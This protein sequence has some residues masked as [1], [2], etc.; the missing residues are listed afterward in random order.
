[1]KY[2]LEILTENT[3][4]RQHKNSVSNTS[5]LCVGLKLKETVIDSGIVQRKE[6]TTVHKKKGQ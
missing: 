3:E 2:E 6:V 1:M 4:W 5:H